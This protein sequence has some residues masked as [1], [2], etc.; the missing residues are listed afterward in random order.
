MTWF[1][2]FT[3]DNAQCEI[4]DHKGAKVLTVD[5]SQAPGVAHDAQGVPVKP[6]VRD[7]IV[8]ALIDRG[9]VDLYAMRAV[10]EALTGANF[11]EGT[12]P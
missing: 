11:E 2:S 12:P 3:E 9:R 8:E 4:Y 7:A 6:D 5:N 10:M 1:Y